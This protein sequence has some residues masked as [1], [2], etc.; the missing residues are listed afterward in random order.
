LGLALISFAVGLFVA[1]RRPW[2]PTARVGAWFIATASIAFGLPNGWAVAWRQA[3]L[4]VQASFWIPEVSRFVLDGIFLTLFLVFPRRLFLARWPWIL[5]WAPVVATLPWRVAQ[6]HTVIY[7]PSE[8]LDVPVWVNQAAFL[9]AIVYL[10]AGI[11]VL[12]VSYRWRLDAH[13]KRRVRVLMVGTAVGIGAAIAQ[14]WFHNFAPE[15]EFSLLRLVF[16]HPLIMACPLAFAYAILRHRMF[17]IQVILRQGLQYALARGA[18][19]GVL[20]VLGALLLLDLALNR[21]E[22]LA[23]I[24]QS[25]GWVYAG[26]GGLALAAYWQRKPWLD[27]LDRRFFREAYDRDQILL[28]LIESVKES[29]SLQEISALVSNEI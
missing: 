25:R 8:T 29:S 4:L 5:I 23:T 21:Q 22:T 18:V 9:R 7:R 27:A 6:F 16:L 11:A 19:I 2:D 13:E 14:I 20:P 10:V 15:L 12:V 3:P 17:G 24:M 28:E 1:F 26:L